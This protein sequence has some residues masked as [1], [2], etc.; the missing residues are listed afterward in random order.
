MTGYDPFSRGPHP[1]GVRTFEVQDAGGER[2][3]STGGEQEQ[4]E[5]RVVPIEV[6]YPATG[7]HAGQDLDP[8]TQDS[9][10]MMPGMP[11]TPQEAVRDADASDEA[12]TPIVFSHGFAG[13]RRQT[14]HLCTH[15]ASH[16]YVVAAPDHVGNTVTEVMGWA[17]SGTPPADMQDYIYECADD[18]PRD[19]S[20]ALDGLLS[21][22]FGVNSRDDGAGI[23]GHSFGGWTALQT[24]ASDER[25]LA[26][27]PLAPAGGAAEL[28]GPDDPRV[29]MSEVLELAWG[30]SV[31][32]L[33]IVADDDSVL[34]LKGMHDIL[35]R[36]E[37]I[38]RM[39][40]LVDADHFHFCDNAEMVHDVMTPVM[41]QGARPSSELVPGAHAYDVTNGLGL[42]HFDAE[43]RNIAE[44]AAFLE[45]DLDELLAERGINV[46]VVQR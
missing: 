19:A 31:P 36:T 42:A 21:G 44:A 33:M 39:V 30:R 10:S 25:I 15:L 24:T 46:E 26:A 1:V 38:D 5:P 43:L 14:T 29:A 7:A 41:G 8:A 11:G 18:R 35:E 40:V 13:H 6:W 34:P 2:D 4:R 12:F 23:S 37:S 28:A 32:T 27:L 45:R 16:G 17:M 3:R 20:R 22:E 9:Y